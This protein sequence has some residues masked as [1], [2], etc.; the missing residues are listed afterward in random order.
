[1]DRLS[2]DTV[3]KEL[4]FAFVALLTY[5]FMQHSGRI[6]SLK[7][8]GYL[9]GFVLI[10]AVVYNLYKAS[11]KSLMPGLLCWG[12]GSNGTAN[13]LKGIKDIKTKG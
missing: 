2:I 11:F 10:S 9:I 8:F 5:V 12:L 1:M 7:G 4:T 13:P 3:I 6:T